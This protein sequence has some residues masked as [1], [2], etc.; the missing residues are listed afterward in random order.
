MLMPEPAWVWL[1]H[2]GYVFTDIRHNNYSF[3]V[4]AAL[5]DQSNL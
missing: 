2:Y 1:R 4:Y 5:A 3:D